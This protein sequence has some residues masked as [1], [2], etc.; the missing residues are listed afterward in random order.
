MATGEPDH[1]DVFRQLEEHDVLFINIVEIPVMQFKGALGTGISFDGSSIRG[2]ADIANADMCLKPDLA[3][4]KIH[5]WPTLM[6]SQEGKY[7]TAGVI[8]D[9]YT[10]EGTPSIH[11]PRYILKRFLQGTAERGITFFVGVEPEF[12][13]FPQGKIPTNRSEVRLPIVS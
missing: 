7:S 5:P 4:L 12:F 10:T 11:S 8:A 3:T 1:R 2:Y 6:E 13:L 9:P